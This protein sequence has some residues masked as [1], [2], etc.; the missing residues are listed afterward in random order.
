M[1]PQAELFWSLAIVVGFLL[2]LIVGAFFVEVFAPKSRTW[3]RRLRRLE[4]GR[5]AQRADQ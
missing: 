3:I 5:A 1:S 4:Q 2:P